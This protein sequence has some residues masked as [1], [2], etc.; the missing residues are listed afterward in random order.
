MKLI[1]LTMKLTFPEPDQQGPQEA[2]TAPHRLHAPSPGLMTV[3]GMGSNSLTMLMIWMMMMN[4]R[5]PHLI[6]C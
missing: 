1:R 5:S 2:P 4:D 6:H 3:G